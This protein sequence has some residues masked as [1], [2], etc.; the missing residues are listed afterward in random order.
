MES[1]DAF[2]GLTARLASTIHL[3]EVA[4]AVVRE[5]AA[6]GFG[7][8]WLAVLDE[9]TGM[10]STLKANID[11]VDATHEF[12]P[13]SSRDLRLP[14]GRAF[15][16]RRMVNVQDPSSL[17]VVD[18]DS[19]RVPPDGFALPRIAY[20]RLRGRPFA[21]G[22]LLGSR[23]EPVG[24]LGLSSYRGTQPIPDAVLTQGPVRVFTDHLGLALE[25][26]LRVGRLDDSLREAR[27]TITSNAP[28]KA[29]GQ[30]TASV[31]H[32]LNNLSGVAL[33]AVEVGLRSPADAFKVMPSIERANR[34]SR[35]LVA[36]LQRIAQ[37][38]S[39]E[40]ET[41]QLSA[42]ID[43]ILTML[44][45]ILRERSIEI[46][47]ELAAVPPVRCNHVTIH[48][49]VLNLLV[50]AQDAL[51]EVPA[52]RRRIRL[53]VRDADGMVRL[54]VSD[55]GPGI[56]PA[57][58]GRLFQPFSTSRGGA[59]LGVG[60]ASSRTALQEFGG[61][62]EAHN[63]PIGG[64]VFE[65]SL[66]AAQ[67]VAEPPARPRPPA[68]AITDTTGRGRILAV[69]D[70]IDV[71]NII[72]EYLNPLGYEV[73]TATD[74]ARALDVASSQGFD[75]VLCDIGMPG[76]SGLDM[77]RALRERG[78]GGKLILMT[79]WD[80]HALSTDPRLS[81]CDT[82]LKKPFRGAEL[83][84]AISALLAHGSG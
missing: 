84:D 33:L 23:G 45:P 6:L 48:R 18:D 24:A 82:L 73:A 36:S 47:T 52:D 46:D 79:G 17:R 25:R 81:E 76:H 57:V 1:L 55:T 40:I 2:V 28:I 60:L 12:P 30:L 34:A 5:S 78:Y 16:D 41:C 35:A 26:A 69:D 38:P 4:D 72:Q 68:A 19:D 43:D 31:A 20:G 8:V 7:A 49:V 71:V 61:Q 29:V 62:I 21:S 83:V 27:E 44:R 3:D 77:P 64:A 37:P 74:P 32:D 67:A 66:V 63:A 10:L 58:L 13:V 65:V 14:A 9:N 80:S 22:P 75:L 11:G 70:D 15:R 51:A 39:G 56:A 42:I 53:R 59:H 50:N 54:T